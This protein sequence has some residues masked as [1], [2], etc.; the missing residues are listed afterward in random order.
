M[1]CGC[2]IGVNY[3]RGK[4]IVNVDIYYMKRSRRF[5]Y[6]LFLTL[7]LPQVGTFDLTLVFN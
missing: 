1:K 2:I 6:I 3:F 4:Q 5:S 7:S